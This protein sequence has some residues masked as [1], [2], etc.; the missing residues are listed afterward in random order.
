[1]CCFSGAVSHVSATQIF[2]RN[3]ARG[4]F[5]VY[6]MNL[7]MAAEVAMILPLPVPPSPTDDAVRFI[8]LSG[9]PDIFT[10]LASTFPPPLASAGPT[11]G[12]APQAAPLKV[13]DVGDFEASFVPSR[14]DFG[15][16][17]PRFRLPESVWDHLPAY[18]DYGFAVFKLRQKARAQQTF[19]PMAFDFPRRD[20][21]AL[22]FP[23][24][25]VHDGKVHPHAHFD[26][27]LYLQTDSILD[28]ES[29]QAPASAF[30][31]ID[32]AQGILDANARVYR[33]KIEGNQPNRDVLVNT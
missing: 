12:F 30:A 11:R 2:A 8:D 23:T 16:V 31:K 26:H 33:R 28:W 4:Q 7:T 17:D 5:L 32:R 15:R 19:H 9:Y 25:H 24:V 22:Y 18:A 29:T 21:H 6:S 10:D 1:M 13:H 14:G 27:T 20:P 3:S